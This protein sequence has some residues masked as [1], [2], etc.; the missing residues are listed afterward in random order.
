M[1]PRLTDLLNLA[2]RVTSLGG[3][4]YQSFKHDQ[5][6]MREYMSWGPPPLCKQAL[7][8]SKFRASKFKSTSLQIQ[9]FEFLRFKFRV[10]KLKILRRFTNLKLRVFKL[11][12]TS[13]QI[14]MC[15]FANSKVRVCKFK[16]S[17]FYASNFAFRN[18]KFYAGLQTWKYKFL[19]SNSRV[20]RLITK[21][22][23]PPGP[24]FASPI[25]LFVWIII[26]A[27]GRWE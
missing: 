8:K 27:N 4:P 11:K 18:L 22:H 20:R 13:L 10:S 19:N 26:R 12:S 16:I 7:R 24:F 1:R 15:E 2:D 14:Q 25:Y 23:G 17:S 6:K 21:R 5:I 3:I 9:N